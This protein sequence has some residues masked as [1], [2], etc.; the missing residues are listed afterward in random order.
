MCKSKNKIP[1]ITHDVTKKK[2]MY[3]HKKYNW[4][5]YIMPIA[6][7]HNRVIPFVDFLVNL[8]ENR[9]KWTNQFLCEI[10]LKHLGG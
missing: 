7:F 6:F 3:Y 4:T 2:I 1:V 8:P 10:L 5:S 9:T